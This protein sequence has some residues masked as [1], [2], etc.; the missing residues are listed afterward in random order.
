MIESLRRYWIALLVLV[1]VGLHASII[2]VIRMQATQAKVLASCEIDLGTFN[3][4]Q[5]SE[6]GLVQLRIHAVVPSAHRIQSRAVFDQRQWE[7][8]QNV[9]ET[10]RQLDPKLLQDPY[11]DHAK[12]LVLDVLVQTIGKEYIDRVLITEMTPQTGRVLVFAKAEPRRYDHQADKHGDHEE[13]HEE[14]GDAHGGDSHG[15]AS[16][17][18]SGGH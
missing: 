6:S 8:R 1:L 5:P 14:S 2:A 3:V 15:K 12:Q 17:G 11:L 10:L 7:L 18:K 9:E 16:H 13:G 4:M